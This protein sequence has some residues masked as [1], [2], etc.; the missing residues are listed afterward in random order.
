MKDGIVKSDSSMELIEKSFDVVVLQEE[1]ESSSVEVD[2]KSLKCVLLKSL[3][4][5]FFLAFLF[6][7]LYLFILLLIFVSVYFNL[8]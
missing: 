2:K 6:F 1:E 7:L 4:L 3:F 8:L 5:K